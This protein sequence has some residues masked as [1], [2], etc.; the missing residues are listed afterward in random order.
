MNELPPF[1]N[2]DQRAAIMRRDNEVVYDRWLVNGK[3]LVNQFLWEH[4]PSTTTLY[5]AEEIACAISEL[6]DEAWSKYQEEHP[7]GQN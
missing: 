7:D 4:L 5:K 6:I 2:E 1:S 3:V